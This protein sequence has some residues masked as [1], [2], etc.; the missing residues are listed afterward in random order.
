MNI[1]QLDFMAGQM[2]RDRR[3]NAQEQVD[4][5]AIA[6]WQSLSNRL[7]SR[8]TEVQSES[9]HRAADLAARDAQQRALREVLNEIAPNHP[10][11]KKIKEIGEAAQIASYRANGY[12]VDMATGKV[13][14]A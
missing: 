12:Q 10:L 14:K 3:A 5:D 6:K 7:Q 4:N 1:S 11:L 9:I 2:A 8:L 13:R